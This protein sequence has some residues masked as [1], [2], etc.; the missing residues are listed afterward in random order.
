MEETPEI[1]NSYGDCT[2]KQFMRCAFE[3]KYGGLLIKGEATDE[4]LKEVFEFIYAQYV[5]GAGL[6]QTREFE[7]MGYIDSLDHR[8]QTVKRFVELQRKFI[9]QFSVPFASAFY[10]VKEYGYTLHWNHEYPDLDLFLKKLDQVEAKETKYKSQ[11]DKKIK[12]L[13]DLRQ[14]KVNKEFTLLESRKEFIS[15][16][17]RLQ[18][19]KFVIDK[20]ET[21]MEDLSIMIKDQ[22]DQIEDERAQRSFKKR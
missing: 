18:Q 7:L 20:N 1:I 16:M 4:K 6:F 9:E 21:S 22:R 15:M 14:K 12:E 13:F 10:L 8:I 2:I 3:E 11:I 5:D 19:A 17:N